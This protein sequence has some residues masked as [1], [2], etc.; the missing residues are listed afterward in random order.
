[1]VVK[2]RKRWTNNKKI[3]KEE[4]AQANALKNASSNK[5][6]TDSSLTK[7]ENEEE[8]LYDTF[9]NHSF[10]NFFIITIFVV[11]PY[12]LN[13]SYYYVFL[14]HPEILTYL[15]LGLMTVRPAVSVTDERQVLIVGSISSGTVQISHELNSK[16]SLEIGHETTDSEWAFVRDGTVSWFHGIRFMKKPSDEKEYVQSIMDICDYNKDKKNMGF[17]PGMYRPPKNNCS[18]REEWS[19]CWK[20]ECIQ[21]VSSEWGCGLDNTCEI[22]FRRNVH[23]V[24]NPLH[25]IESL[26]AK[27]CKLEVT[28]TSTLTSAEKKGEGEGEQS[29]TRNNNESSDSSTTINTSKNETMDASFISF[30]N[31]MFH[32]SHDF[33]DSS[34]CL[35]AASNFV[36]LYTQSLIDARVD[37]GHLDG[38][39]RIEDSS[40]CDVAKVAGLYNI[41]T[42][43]YKP[44][45]ETVRAS[46][47]NN[48]TK[49]EEDNS[50]SNKIE[51]TKNK[52]NQGYVKYTWND[53]PKD[54]EKKVKQLSQKLGYEI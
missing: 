38:F 36:L 13:L 5:E 54:L 32:E 47:L 43:V 40:V 24:R 44:N 51:K 3:S 11:F 31:A 17:H 15:T 4:K 35:E 8:S 12:M 22:N 7:G 20:T 23:Q 29:Q 26:V 14:Q 18:Y 33:R 46:C 41:D 19:E 2:Q 6:E 42:A 39:Y 45:Y 28:D 49:G 37:G 48:S 34:S 25:T 30:A 9:R 16:L 21:I 27:F 50:M 1:M 10:F 52:V 53:F